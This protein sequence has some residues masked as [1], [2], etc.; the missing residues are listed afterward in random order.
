[1]F[2]WSNILFLAKANLIC[3]G[4]IH[5]DFS[6]DKSTILRTTGSIRTN[7]NG[8]QLDISI[9]SHSYFNPLGQLSDASFNV[10]SSNI[11]ISA[12]A[13]GINPIKIDFSLRAFD[14][15]IKY[16]SELKG[17]ILIQEFSPGEFRLEYNNN[18]PINEVYL[19]S[20]AKLISEE[21]KIN[22]S[23]ENSAASCNEK[24]K[25]SLDLSKIIDRF[26]GFTSSMKGTI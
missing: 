5:L 22:I 6:R 18:S 10:T 13:S 23:A 7:L 17:P 21:Y 8:K 15:N 11:E 1:M 20:P 4:E 12:S 16:K 9:K 14:K 26:K 2:S 3:I 24:S 19:K 25:N